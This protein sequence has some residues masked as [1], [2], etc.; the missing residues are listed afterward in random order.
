MQQELFEASLTIPSDQDGTL[1]LTGDFGPAGKPI[2]AF[3]INSKN[4]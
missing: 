1:Q 2:L 3:R 4:N